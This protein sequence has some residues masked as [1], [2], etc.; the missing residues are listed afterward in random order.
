MAA[1]PDEKLPLFPE[2][3]H[4]FPYAGRTLCI[5]VNG[6]QF[7]TNCRWRD[8]A[9]Y[10]MVTVRYGGIVFRKHGYNAYNGWYYFNSLQVTSAT[11]PPIPCRTLHLCGIGS[12]G[13]GS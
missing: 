9:P 7:A 6:Q 10:R 13:R 5:T 8:S 12:G 1:A 3:T 4:S 11:D 2:P